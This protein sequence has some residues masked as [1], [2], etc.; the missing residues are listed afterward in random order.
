MNISII[1]PVL[2][3][4][5]RIGSLI[6]SLREL[7]A[8]AETTC[9]LIVVDGGSNDET[10]T[11]A[12]AADHVVQSDP[13]RA[14]QQNRGAK[15]SSGEILLFLHADS[16]LTSGCLES[17]RPTLDRPSVVMGC[18]EQQ[19]D[20]PAAKYRWI[21]RGNTRRV[22]WLQWAYGDQGLFLRRDLFEAVGG[23][24]EEPFLEDLLLSKRL[25]K[26]GKIAVS[27]HKI[28]VSPRRWEKRGL[29]RQTLTNWTIVTL[30]ACGVPPTKLKKLYPHVR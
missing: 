20:H 29:I 14:T 13:G 21:E 26:R 7:A 19:I 8:E 11:E 23:F 6:N 30:A 28:V 17:I 9:E 5:G 15:V 10:V 4:E 27:D 18:F 2:N 12:A 16:R 1:I 3:E 24:P 22:H 25:A